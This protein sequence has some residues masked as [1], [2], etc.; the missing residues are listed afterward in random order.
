[1]LSAAEGTQD[2]SLRNF[3]A[4]SEFRYQ[5]RKYLRFSEKAARALGLEPQQHQLLL[6]IRGYAGAGCGP[7]IGYLAERLQVRHHSAVELVDRMETRGMVHRQPG[8][9]DRRQVIV[10]LS[11]AGQQIL[12]DFATQ[13]LAEM[14][15]IGPDLVA[16]LQQVLENA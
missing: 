16:A 6:A 13:H 8:E 2:I 3:R 1:M 11:H 7:T 10:A 15:Q 12:Q 14:Q 4:L 5:I 9:R